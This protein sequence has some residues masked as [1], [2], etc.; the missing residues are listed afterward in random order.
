MSR[1]IVVA[2][3]FI[4]LYHAA[5]SQ[6][7]YSREEYIQKYRELAI[8]E[9]YR[10]R[11]PASIT[12]AQGCL[13]SGNGNS[14]LSRRSNNH[15][16]IKCRSDWKGKRVYF[17][18]D[19]PDECFRAYNSVEDSYLD[20]SKFLI[21]NSRY[22]DLFKLRLDD[23]KGWAHGLKKAG[24]ATSPSYA[25]DLIKIIETNKLHVYDKV[26][27]LKQ[28]SKYEHLRLT[29][30]TTSSLAS[31]YNNLTI[32]MRN[33]L[34]TITV[35]T[36]ETMRSIANDLYIP[37]RDLYK[38]NDYPSRREPRENEI[39]YI[40]KK[41]RKTEKGVETHVVEKSE[42]LHYISQM[43]GIRLN[44]LCRRNGISKNER[45]N[46]GTVIFLRKSPR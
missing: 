19:A 26:T 42:T 33:N 34:R 23:Y 21:E 30:K 43:Y 10:A 18:D 8:K 14:T 11:I 16:G 29:N 37:V 6:Q 25:Q 9:M 24:Y 20:H 39:L 46:P 17:T 44:I 32:Y 22:G 13:E 2:I 1:K 27:D 35:K 3:I 38:Y 41:A 12:L 45:L 15:F 5:I 4:C 40:E 31:P 36:N 28:L 7:I